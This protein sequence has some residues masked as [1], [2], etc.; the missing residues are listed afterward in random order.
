MK[1][2]FIV[3]LLSIFYVSTISAEEIKCNTQ[4]EKI[5]P[6]CSK[7]LKSAGSGLSKIFKGMHEIS[8]NYQAKPNKKKFNLREFSEKHKTIGDTLG[9]S[10][11]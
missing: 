10:K 3:T 2:I 8:S 4:L 11:K 1:K 7:V 6:A 5:N 9:K